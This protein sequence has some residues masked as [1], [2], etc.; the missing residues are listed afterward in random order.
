MPE[1]EE[2]FADFL[3]VDKSQDRLIKTPTY[4]SLFSGP[5]E[6]A[7]GASTTSGNAGMPTPEEMR[8]PAAPAATEA[9]AEGYGAPARLGAGPASAP[10]SGNE[11]MAQESPGEDMTEGD[12]RVPQVATEGPPGLQEE[13]PVGPQGMRMFA[14]GGERGV[15]QTLQFGPA[16]D[17]AADGVLA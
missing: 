9:V 15:P 3:R 7:P 5:V 17:S 13:T 2:L 16:K 11:Q 12:A 6:A 8:A 1:E 14:E 10:G 4:A